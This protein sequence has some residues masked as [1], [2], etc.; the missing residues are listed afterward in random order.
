[1]IQFLLWLPLG[2][3][4]LAAVAPRRLSSVLAVAGALAALV[5]AIIVVAG[6]DPSGG[7]QHNV[8]ESWIPDLGVRYQL[9]IDGIS[10]FLVLLTAALWFAATAWSAIRTPERPKTW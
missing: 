7:L 9:G 5:L 1:M 3:G 10:V 4:L 6:F 8:D 2:A